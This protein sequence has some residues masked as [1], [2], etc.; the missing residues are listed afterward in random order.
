MEIVKHNTDNPSLES[1]RD[2]FDSEAGHPQN[3]LE[4]E[5]SKTSLR[6]Q[7]EAQARVIEKQ[8]GGL[9][10]VRLKLGLSQRKICQL[11]LVDPS[12]WS[13]WMK[14]E[15][16][17]PHVFRALQW[18]LIIQEKI[19]GLT[20]QYFIGKDPEVLHRLAMNRI[21]NERVHREEMVKNVFSQT[22]QLEEELK[23]LRAE[24]EKLA[25]LRED[26]VIFKRKVFDVSLVFFGVFV[27]LS[28]SF[29]LI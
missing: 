29:W 16:P 12:A 24:N 9:E 17:P 10:G 8:I 3:T 4:S 6:M 20:P 28:V 11:L 23:E 2:L 21:E 18:Y 26:F 14:S 5:R 19:P 13:R 27:V 7:Y 25:R 15:N 22:L 1:L